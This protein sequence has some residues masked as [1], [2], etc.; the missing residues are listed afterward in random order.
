VPVQEAQLKRNLWIVGSLTLAV[1][2]AVGVNLYIAQG[3]AR[4]DEAS[5]KAQR[6]AS[7]IGG[8]DGEAA[9]VA[10]LGLS[11]TQ[12]KALEA[13]RKEMRDSMRSLGKP[14]G[15][16]SQAMKEMERMRAK[17]DAVLTPEQRK[18]MQER[19][20]TTPPP[21]GGMPPFG[22]AP[23]GMP[24]GGPLPFGSAGGTR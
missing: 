16:P 2:L 15:D 12:Q 17:M 3:Q 9:M 10:D 7:S 22:G 4:A 21:M 18:R 11:E 19:M 5:L 6:K 20:A 8:P 1:G 14:N 24:P 23:N 13:I